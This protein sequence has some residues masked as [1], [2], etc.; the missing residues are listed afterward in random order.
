MSN[1]RNDLGPYNPVLNWYQERPGNAVG[2]VAALAQAAIPQRQETFRREG[3]YDQLTP[4]SF[5]TTY[6]K[7]IPSP[8]LGQPLIWVYNESDI[9]LLTCF[10]FIFQ[11]GA[12]GGGT[13][14]FEVRLQGDIPF[15]VSNVVV[16]QAQN[17][18]AII[19]LAT[20]WPQAAV[21]SGGTT[22]FLYSNG[23]L[24]ENLELSRGMSICLGR[25][26]YSGTPPVATAVLRN[27]WFGYR[28]VGNA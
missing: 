20:N 11:T 8:G 9:A 23:W 1:D 19:F 6:Y 21:Q 24:P 5:G 7:P 13:L 4:Q 2:T 22:P 12:G 26:G 25:T 18:T 14:N 17:L 16:T 27:I 15:F 28:K 3:I 10:S